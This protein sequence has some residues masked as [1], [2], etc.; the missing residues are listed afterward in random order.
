VLLRVV[1]TTGWMSGDF[2]V[3]AQ[4]S[5]DGE[6]LLSE[7]V[8]AFAAEGVELP[9]ST[10]HEFIGDF[11]PTVRALGL[12]GFMHAIA[13]TEMTTTASG[14]FNIFPLTPRP[15]LL[16]HGGLNWYNRAIPD[17]LKE[18]RARL[19]A[20]GLTPIVQMN[21]PRSVG[22]AY[23]DAVHFDPDSFTAQASP[24]D[25][26]DNWDAMEIWNGVDLARFEGCPTQAPGCVA[27]YHPTAFD[28]FAFL[29]RR[30]LVT[31][32]GNSDSHKASLH[33][34][35]YPRNYVY[36]GGDDPT[37]LRDPA[38]MA[39]LRAQKVVI[40]GGPFLVT[41]VGPVMPGGTATA[42]VVNGLSTIHLT[43]DIQAPTWMGPLSQ[44]DVWMGDTSPN[45]GHIAKTI[46][47]PANGSAVLRYHATVDVQTPADTWLVAT[48]R[49]PVD[50][51]G[52]SHALWPVVEAPLPPF[53]ITNPIWVDADGDGVV[54]PLRP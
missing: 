23:L 26:S 50:A 1:D 22:M 7:K 2:H 48:V 34:V 46:V 10:E 47:L 17:V 35:G 44:V 53:A 15:D 18:A 40:S 5:P 32:T 31:G 27:P 21:H 12:Q 20:D 37:A 45:G 38:L 51:D 49:G 29:D 8:R 4:F 42:E 14:H 33:E 52:L 41:S 6:D 3:H 25:W 16:N 13:G 43:L 54:R 36:V 39:A 30:K 11:G 24:A 9:V 19:T 28:W